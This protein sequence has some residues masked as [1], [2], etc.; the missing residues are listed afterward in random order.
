FQFVE[1][2]ERGAEIA[3]GSRPATFAALADALEQA[4][5]FRRDRRGFD[6]R[7]RD[8]LLKRADAQALLDVLDGR[9]PLMVH[10]ERASDIR[11]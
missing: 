9:T 8:A 5:D 3:G 4:E 11:A 1:M 10:A 7:G 6:G 2:G